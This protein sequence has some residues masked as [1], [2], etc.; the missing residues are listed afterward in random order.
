M[1]RSC[2]YQSTLLTRCCSVALAAQ[3]ADG[4]IELGPTAVNAED[5]TETQGHS[6][7]GGYPTQAAVVDGGLRGD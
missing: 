3:A 7:N 1:A 5:W 2:A 6:A 4:S